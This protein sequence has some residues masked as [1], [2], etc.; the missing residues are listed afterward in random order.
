[1]AVLI[2]SIFPTLPTDLF[3]A[4]CFHIPKNF[5]ATARMLRKT[6]RLMFPPSVDHVKNWLTRLYYTELH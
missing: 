2:S 3:A 1:M 5:A 6:D 4:K